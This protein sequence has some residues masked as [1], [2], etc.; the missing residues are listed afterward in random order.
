M[1]EPRSVKLQSSGN[2]YLKIT[3]VIAI[4]VIVIAII[5]MIIIIIISSVFSPLSDSFIFLLMST[6]MELYVRT[7]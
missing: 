1:L 6:S 7:R 3:I 4:I 5:I 2:Y